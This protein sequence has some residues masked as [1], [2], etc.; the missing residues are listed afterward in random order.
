M[1]KKLLTAALLTVTALTL[2]VASV[3]GTIAYLT[4]NSGVS[5]VFTVGNIQIQMFEHKV[6]SNGKIP[7]TGTLEEVSA[8]TYHLIPNTTYDKNP[9]I[10]ITSKLKEDEMYLFVKSRNQIRAI[11]AANV[12]GAPSTTPKS[13]REQMTANGWVE[14]LRSGDGIEI[15]WVYG[16]RDPVT[17]V[18]TPTAVD[19][20]SKQVG[21]DGSEVTGT[22]GLFRLCENFTIAEKADV[23]R[24]AAAEVAFMAFA[25]QTSGFEATDGTIDTKSAWDAIKDAYP[26]EGGILNPVNPYNPNLKNDNAYDAVEDTPEATKPNTNPGTGEVG[27]E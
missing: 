8:N 14:Y 20:T 11:E 2:V 24:Y 18:I 6:G 21:K 5:N 4:A 17:G 22:A 23:A 10:R 15:V 27:G 25:I 26:Y 3:L 1:K 9:T 13:M 16:T 7:T 12:D 19:P